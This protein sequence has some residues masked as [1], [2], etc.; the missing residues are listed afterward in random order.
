MGEGMYERLTKYAGELSKREISSEFGP[1]TI[2]LEDFVSDFCGMKGFAVT[3]YRATLIRHGASLKEGGL[4][5]YDIEHADVE[6]VRAAITW[7]LRAERFCGGALAD[8]AACGFLDRCLMRL[9]E[10]DEG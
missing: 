10:L 9:R 6:C 7:C 4:R 5:E 2:G 1:G 8:W 3:D